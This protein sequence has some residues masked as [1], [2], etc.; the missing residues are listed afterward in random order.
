[1]PT[2]IE[3]MRGEMRVM[4]ATGDTKVC[5]SSGNPDEVESAK[6]TFKKLKAKGYLAYKVQGDGNKGEVITEFDPMAGLLIMAP[7]MAGG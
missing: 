7:P 3:E 6:D 2:M 5:W 4:D 1:M